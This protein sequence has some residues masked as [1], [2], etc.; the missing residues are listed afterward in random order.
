MA[1]Y[2]DA[3]II[4]NTYKNKDFFFIVEVA[5]KDYDGEGNEILDWKEHSSINTNNK[6]HTVDA[7]RK[8]RDGLLGAILVESEVVE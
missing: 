3:R 4:K 2:V 8:Y 6:F 7:A 1:A 5:Y